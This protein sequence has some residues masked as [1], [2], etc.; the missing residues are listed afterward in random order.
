MKRA[1]AIASVRHVLVPSVS[2][3]KSVVLV[4]RLKSEISK[5]MPRN[6]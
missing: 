5:I 4:P 1:V 6:F 3:V 2:I